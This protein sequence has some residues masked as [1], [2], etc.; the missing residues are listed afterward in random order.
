M[1]RTM[2]TKILYLVDQYETSQ[3]GTEGQLLHLLRHL[4]RSRYEPSLTLL[5]G[6]DYVER[7]TFPC[8]VRVLGITRLASLTAIA[9]MLRY[10]LL[11]RRE[12]VRLVHCFFND[13]ALLAP[14]FLRLAG[15]RVVVSRRDMG[16]WYTPAIL[17]VLRSMRPFVDRYIAN[18]QAVKEL[19]RVRERVPREKIEVIYNGYPDPE[20]TSA[21]SSETQPAE[22]AGYWPV[23]GIVANLRPVKRIDT[24]VEALALVRKKYPGAVLAVVGDTSSAQAQTTLQQ[25]HALAS[26]LSIR[27]AIIFTGRV[28][29]PQAYIERFSA[30]V[31]CSES[32][33][34]SNALIEYMLA[35]RPVVCTDTGGNPELV[36][37]GYNGFWFNIGDADRLADRLITLL[38][39]PALAK[40]LGAAAYSTIMSYTLSRML[41][42]QMACYDQ[43]CGMQRT[44]R[45]T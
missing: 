7:N 20:K 13:S 19:V 41:D 32:E 1:A 6:S 2:P 27:D 39:D 17:A 31:L 38:G 35:R 29:R 26:R 21:D 10:A 40:Q 33:G 44:L 23:I 36:Q 8:P 45:G 12:K 30:A 3:A 37:D 42:A 34:L 43:V 22:L 16:F 11:L 4:D 14:A 5:R 25:L 28:A 15:I 18:S 24:A 9:R